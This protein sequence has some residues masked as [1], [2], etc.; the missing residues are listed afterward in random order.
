VTTTLHLRTVALWQ[1]DWALL[2]EEA[3][4]EPLPAAREERPSGVLIDRPASVPVRVAVPVG[5]QVRDGRL[6]AHCCRL[7]WDA[8]TLLHAA[9]GERHG[10][11]IEPAAEGRE[12][13][14]P[15]PAHAYRPA[16]WAIAFA[17]AAGLRSYATRDPECGQIEA[18][19]DPGRIRTWPDPEQAAGWLHKVGLSEHEPV[20]IGSPGWLRPVI[21]QL[22]PETLRGAD[23][24][25][26][27][28]WSMR[29]PGEPHG[30]RW[31]Q[32]GREEAPPP[33]AARTAA[34]PVQLLLFGEALA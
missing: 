18:T 24:P 26:G 22:D 30:P 2:W 25:R 21:E 12:T 23:W 32:Q 31:Y 5:S 29:E 9:R 6:V 16:T 14:I 34:R 10:C 1:G 20:P 19:T 4:F 3:A 13:P 7:G 17:S 11:R 27:V 15:G 28:E 8:A 33:E